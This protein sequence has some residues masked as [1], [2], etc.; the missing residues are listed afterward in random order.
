[1]EAVMVGSVLVLTTVGRLVWY[2]A[3][4]VLLYKIWQELKRRP[5]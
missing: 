4:V 3:V 5:A 1:M 2:V